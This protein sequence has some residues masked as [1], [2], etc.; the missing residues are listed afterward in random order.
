MTAESEKYSYASSGDGT[1]LH[2]SGELFNK[3]AGVEMQPIRYKGSGPALNDVLGNQVPI[4][5]DNLPSSS[6]Q[7]CHW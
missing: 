7:I 1:P 4:M 3:M 2:L 5:F 6:G